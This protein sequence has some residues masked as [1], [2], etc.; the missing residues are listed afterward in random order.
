MLILLRNVLTNS[1]PGVA[2]EAQV[3]NSSSTPLAQ[4][5][6]HSCAAGIIFSIPF[7]DSI[8]HTDLA[9]NANK[10]Y[11]IQ[12]VEYED[13]EYF[14][15][16]RWG[17]GESG[18]VQQ[19]GPLDRDAGGKQFNSKFKEKTGNTWDTRASFVIKKSKY[20]LV[21]LEHDSPSQIQS[22]R[23]KTRRNS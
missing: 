8:N 19:V 6:A 2:E 18:A 9:K 21:V 16:T 12:L 10:Y 5:L 7:F 15:F 23:K 20:S 1:N 22:L 11:L 3:H 14:V 17:R 4:C 13:S